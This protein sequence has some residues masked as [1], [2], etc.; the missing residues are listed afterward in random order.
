MYSGNNFI[1]QGSSP[2][3]GRNQGVLPTIT[4]HR[5]VALLTADEFIQ[6]LY[7]AALQAFIIH[8]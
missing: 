1:C 3:T 6:V 5:P 8:C 2:N 7:A 4:S